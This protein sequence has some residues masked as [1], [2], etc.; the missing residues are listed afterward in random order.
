MAGKKVYC[1]SCRKSYT[2]NSKLNEDGDLVRICPHCLREDPVKPIRT[3]TH[4]TE[5]S[6]NF[7]SEVDVTINGD[8]V[9][10][11][12]YCG[13]EHC[14]VVEDGVITSDR[15]STR[16]HRKDVFAKVWKSNNFPIQTSTA[17]QFLRDKWLRVGVQ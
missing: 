10:I 1:E 5:C 9:V 7:I 16:S 2:A 11:C 13:H 12:P 6:K 4:C 17:S 8:H 15:W 14:R 3:D